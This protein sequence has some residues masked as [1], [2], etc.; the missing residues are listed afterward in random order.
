M[1]N[2]SDSLWAPPF[3]KWGTKL[4]L[5]SILGGQFRV[6]ITATTE[7]NAPSSVDLEV[8]YFDENGRHRRE[9][10]FDSIRFRT[11]RDAAQEITVRARSH[12]AGQNLRIRWSMSGISNHTWT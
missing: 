3:R 7:S 5:P 9:T 1:P 8:E 2:G 12:G 11:E 10:F 6:S 4:R